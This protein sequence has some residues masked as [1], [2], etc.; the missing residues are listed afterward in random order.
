LQF[1][2]LSLHRG[3]TSHKEGSLKKREE[4]RKEGR[5]VGRKVPRI[6]ARIP[7][8]TKPAKRTHVSAWLCD[9]HKKYT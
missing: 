2:F 3:E 4:G 8:Q 7:N 6:S 1:E 5:K 9:S